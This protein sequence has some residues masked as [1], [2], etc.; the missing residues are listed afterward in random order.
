MNGFRKVCVVKGAGFFNDKIDGELID[1]GSV[2]I[3]EQLDESK[4]RAKGF[5]TVEYRCEN[6]ELAARLC[7]GELPAQF[8]VQFEIVTSKRGQVIRVVDAVAFKGTPPQPQPMA[9]AA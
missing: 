5:R 7:K 8:D 3:E 1:S 9:K 6:H 2:F 4:G